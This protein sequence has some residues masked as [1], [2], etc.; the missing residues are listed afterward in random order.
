MKRTTG[1]C[2]QILALAASLTWPAH[3]AGL[4]ASY[5]LNPLPAL[6][7]M[8]ATVKVGSDGPTIPGEPWF[9]VKDLEFALGDN[10]SVTSGT[11]TVAL[12]SLSS[13]KAMYKK[14]V[15]TLGVNKPITYDITGTVTPDQVKLI[16]N[17]ENQV[18]GGLPAQLHDASVQ[19]DGT[20]IK[21]NL[22]L[23]QTNGEHYWKQTIP[24]TLT[25]K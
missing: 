2:T 20:T 5:T 17:Q 22:S 14:L 21:G 1:R 18:G 4:A 19:S 7:D 25:P 13:P 10:G 9:L 16:F 15:D 12:Q 6:T 3:G 23:Y 11:L 24:V 8:T